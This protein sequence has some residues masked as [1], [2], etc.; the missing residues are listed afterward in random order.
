MAETF[1]SVQGDGGVSPPTPAADHTAGALA[2]PSVGSACRTEAL[3][4]LESCALE[5]ESKWK[6]AGQPDRS[7]LW[8]SEPQDRSPLL[9]P[10]G[11]QRGAGTNFPLSTWRC[12]PPWL[13]P[14]SSHTFGTEVF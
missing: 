7:P 9:S 1:K 6:W 4:P 5:N 14:K 13:V 10:D 8:R 2:L 3:G 12:H 11:E